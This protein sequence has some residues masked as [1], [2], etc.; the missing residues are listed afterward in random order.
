MTNEQKIALAIK[1][2]RASLAFAAPEQQDIHWQV[3]HER[4]SDIIEPD[5]IDIDHPAVHAGAEA[6]FGQHP[7]RGGQE[8]DQA[9]FAVLTAALPYLFGDV[10]DQ[11]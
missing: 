1:S 9:V 6:L 4:L 10:D 5:E 3:L 11:G 8:R 7:E 2:C